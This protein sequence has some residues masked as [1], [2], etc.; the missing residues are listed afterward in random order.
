M[1]TIVPVWPSLWRGDLD[2]CTDPDCLRLDLECL[3]DI[4][5]ESEDDYSPEED[6]DRFL[7]LLGEEILIFL[8]LLCDLG[9]AYC[10]GGEQFLGKKCLIGV[11]LL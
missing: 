11:T 9:E 5:G 1:P 10:L 4:K 2:L 8:G 6:I 3:L 7:F